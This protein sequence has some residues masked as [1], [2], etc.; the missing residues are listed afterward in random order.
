[1]KEIS[2]S[3]NPLYKSWL[4]LTR[5]TNAKGDDLL[6]EGVH[7]CQTWLSR[8]GMPQWALFKRGSHSDPEVAQLAASVPAHRQVWLEARLMRGLSSL[9]SE[10][11]VMFV[12]QRPQATLQQQWCDGA[13]VLDALQDPGNVG[14]LIRTAAAA[15]VK[16]VIAG[17]GSAS[18]WSAKALRAGQGAQ[19]HV[20][21]HEAVDLSVW[22]GTL[23]SETDPSKRPMVI[24]TTLAQA[25]TGLFDLDLPERVIWVF[26][27][28]GKGVS[29]AL[30]AMA[31][32]CVHIPHEAGAVESLNVASAAAICLFEHRRQRRV[33]QYD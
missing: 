13:V 5:Q 27:H 17:L 15:G 1:M 6:L 8:F 33:S 7:I 25:S 3:S 11:T 22:L 21:I 32:R 20:T 10:P 29:A 24:A 26:G 14:T 4:R 16:H 12:A 23:V 30:A 18:C 19:F 28:E 2:S 31:D 9:S